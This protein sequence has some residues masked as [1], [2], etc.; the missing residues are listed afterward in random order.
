MSTAER[1]SWGLLSLIVLIVWLRWHYTPTIEKRVGPPQERE[2][3]NPPLNN[4][5]QERNFPGPKVHK[6]QS[7]SLGPTLRG[8]AGGA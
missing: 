5:H 2:D 4:N 1:I 3:A 8:S 6:G 7:S